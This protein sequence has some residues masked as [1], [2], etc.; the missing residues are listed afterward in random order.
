MKKVLASLFALSIVLAA[1]S[2]DEDKEPKKDDHAK[3]EQSTKQDKNDHKEQASSK[4]KDESNSSDQA[5]TSK[6][7]ANDQ[8]ND[9]QSEMNNQNTEGKQQQAQQNDQS[10]STQANGQASNQQQNNSQNEQTSQTKSQYVAPYQGGNVVPVA[11]NIAREKVNRQQALQN[12]PNF[13]VALDSARQE[14][15]QLNGQQNPYN[16][17][18]L[19][20][21]GGQYSYLFSFINQSQPGTYVIVTVDYTGTAKIIDPTYRQ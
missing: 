8:N 5:K 19:Q 11:Q 7:D 2:N 10:S 15:G 18:A 16:D 14:V 12:L 13:Q 21:A 3:Q 4:S 1:C 20:G 17:Y 6:S 9:Q